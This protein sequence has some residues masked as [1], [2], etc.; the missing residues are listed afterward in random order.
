M[1][2]PNLYYPTQRSW[3]SGAKDPKRLSFAV[4]HGELLR[5]ASREQYRWRASGLLTPGRSIQG[6]RGPDC[7]GR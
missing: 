2:E 7:D 3:A 1:I 6:G 5:H 4:P